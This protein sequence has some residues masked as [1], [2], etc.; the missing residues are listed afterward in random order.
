[1]IIQQG[2]RKC[3]EQIRWEFTFSLSWFETTDNTIAIF[4]SI[5]SSRKAADDMEDPIAIMLKYL[6]VMGN[7]S[8]KNNKTL[9]V[10]IPKVYYSHTYHI[11]ADLAKVTSLIFISWSIIHSEPFEKRTVLP[12]SLMPPPCLP[13][14]ER[15][16]FSYNDKDNLEFGFL[17]SIIS[18]HSVWKTKQR[19]LWVVWA[20]RSRISPCRCNSSPG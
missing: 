4:L 14:G 18:Q 2:E 19:W 8:T 16:I 20:A 5:V 1:M 15:P 7:I 12:M 13:P 10:P 6:N 9:V 3:L 11:K 17:N